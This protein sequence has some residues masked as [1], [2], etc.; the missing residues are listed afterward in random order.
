MAYRWDPAERRLERAE[1][2]I[3]E[4]EDVVAVSRQVLEDTHRFLSAM[5]Y[6]EGDGYDAEDGIH[7]DEEWITTLMWKLEHAMAA[8]KHRRT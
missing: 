3:G 2:K 6:Q 8:C 1:Q 7:I 5:F 4:L